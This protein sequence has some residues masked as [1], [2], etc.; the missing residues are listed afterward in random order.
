MGRLAHKVAIVTGGGSGIGRATALGMAREGARVVVA[1][2]DDAAAKGTLDEISR[3]EG[4]GLFQHTDVGI[5]ADVQELVRTAMDRYG[6]LD[7]MFNNVG[8]AIP[9]S[10]TEISEEN[11]NR[12]LNL[13]L[14][15]VWRGMRY[16]IPAMLQSGGGVIIS[17]SSVQSFVGFHGWSA[18]SAS[19]GG[20]N[21]LTQQAAVEY[22]KD[23]IRINAVAPS[24]IMT[25]M[26]ERIFATAA[27]P[28][29]LVDNWNNMHPL[30][31]FGQ[32]EEVAAAVIFLA[33]DEASFI[34]GEILRVDGGMILRA[35]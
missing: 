20:I 2:I 10:V 15:S 33:S 4:E 30:G 6:H 18:Y 24:T 17:S 23:K 32:P 7:I 34:T 11:W 35:D 21:A 28:Q 14:S 27:N 31:R 13:N 8:V 22:A 16:A 5:S 9:G 25:P 29:E 3:N 12:V 1:D 26:N 19:K